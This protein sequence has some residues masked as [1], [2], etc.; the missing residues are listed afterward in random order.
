MRRSLASTTHVWSR[1]PALKPGDGLEAALKAANNDGQLDGLPLKDGRQPAIWELRAL[2]ER[3]YAELTRTSLH[4]LRQAMAANGLGGALMDRGTYSEDRDAARRGL[5][6][7]KNATDE[8][9]RPFVLRFE[10]AASGQLLT[11]ETVER[12]YARFGPRL[13]GEL[14]RRVIDLSELDPT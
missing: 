1:D 2:S 12:L 3:G 5:I 6:S 10:D 7:V 4:D 13:I 8:D 11:A 14:G 9:G